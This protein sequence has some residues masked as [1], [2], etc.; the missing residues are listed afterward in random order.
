M[1]TTLILL[2]IYILISKKLEKY[3]YKLLKNGKDLKYL[4]CEEIL[5]V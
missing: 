3:E 2:A 4:L 5:C 1:I